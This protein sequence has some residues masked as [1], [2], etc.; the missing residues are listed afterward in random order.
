MK[1]TV[2]HLTSGELEKESAVEAITSVD[3]NKPGKYENLVAKHAGQYASTIEQSKL[4]ETILPLGKATA[5]NVL[6]LPQS[7]IVSTPLNSKKK[8]LYLQAYLSNDQPP[9]DQK[10]HSWLPFTLSEDFK[11]EEQDS[12]EDD[13]SGKQTVELDEKG[14][15]LFTDKQRIEGGLE[16]QRVAGLWDLGNSLGHPEPKDGMNYIEGS[17]ADSNSKRSSNSSLKAEQLLLKISREDANKRGLMLAVLPLFLFLVGVIFQAQFEFDRYESFQLIYFDLSARDAQLYV[18]WACFLHLQ[19]IE[20]RRSVH[21]GILADDA[22][23]NFGMASIEG[24]ILSFANSTVYQDQI[25]VHSLR[26][27]RMLWNSSYSL[28]YNLGAIFFDRMDFLDYDPI[29]RKDFFI[30]NDSP[31]QIGLRI[32]P[33]INKRF[34][35]PYSDFPYLSGGDAPNPR[36][37]PEEFIMRNAMLNTYGPYVLRRSLVRLTQT[38]TPPTKS[39]RTSSPKRER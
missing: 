37:D 10:T 35:R 7:E 5:E 4:E 32:Q 29:E 16:V 30:H 12:G 25:T 33:A 36:D 26:E 9:T 11:E 27:M 19:H 34:T 24:A 22:F 20:F 8:G 15:E 38:S 17:R 3:L 2:P 14:G 39:T 1:V 23:T 18:F 31:Y 28:R 13:K 21:Q 6:K